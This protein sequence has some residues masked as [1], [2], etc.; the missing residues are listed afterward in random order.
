MFDE[1]LLQKQSNFERCDLH[2]EEKG[3]D[4]VTS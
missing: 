3:R 4:Y 2:D 1:H